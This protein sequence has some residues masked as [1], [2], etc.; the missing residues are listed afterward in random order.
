MS[1]IE[2]GEK[3]ITKT[4]INNIITPP[5]APKTPHIIPMIKPNIKPETITFD[6]K[7]FNK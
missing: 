7:I 5:P 3:M 4:K 2:K 6:L 1:S